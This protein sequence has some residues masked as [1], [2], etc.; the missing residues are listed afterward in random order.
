MKN[1]CPFFWRKIISVLVIKLILS[2]VF[3]LVKEVA[4]FQVINRSKMKSS[5]NE[6]KIKET[7]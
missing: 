7:R 5:T 3:I 1:H 2:L 6:G 4:D